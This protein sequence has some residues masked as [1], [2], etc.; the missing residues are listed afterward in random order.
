MTRLLIIGLMTVVLLGVFVGLNSCGETRPASLSELFENPPPEARPWA[1][2]YWMHGALSKDGLTRDLEAMKEAGFEGAYIFTIRGVPDEP[3][4][5][6][7]YHQL[8]PEWWEMVLHALSEAQRLELQIA[9]HVSDGFALAGGP[10]ISPEMSMQK[11]VWSEQTVRG[12]QKFD[13]LLEQPETVADYYKD[14]AVYAY[15]AVS[16]AA[17]STRTQRPV[18]TTSIPGVDALVLV[19]QDNELTISSN[20]PAWIQYAFEEPFLCRS[21]SVKSQWADYQSRRL[22]IQVSDDGENFREVL[23]L[24]PPRMGWQDYEYASTFAIGEVKSRFFRFVFDPIGSE[25]GAEDLDPAK[26]SPRLRIRGLELFSSP[27]INQYEGKSGAVWRISPREDNDLVPGH[28]YMD[29]AQVVVLSSKMD[30]AGRLEWEVPPGD[31]TILRMGH[32]STGH[33]NATGGA[34]IGLEADK[35]NPEAVRLQFDNWLGAAVE[36]AGPDLAKVISMF[37]V[38]S[39]E[40]GSQNWSPVFR[41]EF[42]HRRGYDPLSY[43]PIMAGVPLG[44]AEFSERFLYDVRS[45]ISDLVVENFFGTLE[46]LANE[47]GANFSAESLSPVF[48][49][50]DME[51]YRHVNHPMG[52][53]WLNSPSHDKPN[54][55]LDAIS[56]A[57]MYGH[58]IVQAE[59]FTQVRMEWDEHPGMLKAL[60]D[61]HFALGVNRFVFHVF[62]HNPWMEQKQPG[63]TL[64]G[65]GLFLQPDQTWWK[66]GF[67]WFD[68][69][70]RSQALLQEGVPVADVA[71]FTGEEVP[72]RALLPDRLVTVLPGLFGPDRVEREVERLSNTELKTRQRPVGVKTSANMAV[73]EDWSDPLKGY[74]Y[75]SFNKDALMNLATVKDGR[76]VL[77][78]GASYG[79]LVIPGSRRMN[80]DA[81]RM[82]LQV[83]R[84]ILELVKE[85]GTVVFEERP[86]QTLGLSAMGKDD[87]ELQ[88]IMAE[89]WD[90]EELVVADPEEGEITY[91]KVGKGRV[92]KGSYEAASLQPIGLSRDLIIRDA[93]GQR[94]E[95]VAWVHRQADHAEIYFLSN[96]TADR[97]AL[98]LSFR[99]SGLRPW[100]Y[101]AVSGTIEEVS[102]WEMKDGRTDL[103]LVLEPNGSVFVVFEGPTKQKKREGS[104]AMEAALEKRF[105]IQGPWRV[106]FDSNFGGPSEEVTLEHLMDWT[107]HE[108]ESVQTYSGTAKY[109]VDFDWQPEANGHRYWLSPGS[110]GSIAEVR[111]NGKDLGVLWTPPF[112]LEVTDVLQTGLNQL[113]IFITNTWRNR[114]LADRDKA[115]EER[116][117]DFFG[118]WYIEGKDPMPSGLLGPVTIVAR[119]EH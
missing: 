61:K 85:G 40:C 21:L 76:I 64:D 13:Q 67:A 46:T 72:R 81:N 26:W 71:V 18:V 5:E 102:S 3:L 70:T 66:P 7:S 80:P 23:R 101:D 51:H 56:G 98:Q 87:A 9:Y 109:C 44:S 29:T 53:F 35:L 55:I 110:F 88:A 84:K 49:S 105:A 83:A 73:W 63:M 104:P 97:N 11:L 43:L 82:S 99:V 117:A 50:D 31:W 33:T 37:H 39:W 45:T 28:L 79:V 119:P 2:W 25:P 59:A 118:R 74:A 91:Q 108:N 34:A 57:R 62:M 106:A 103:D 38:D 8:S 65:I 107:L 93:D 20:S 95:Q 17:H 86:T 111:L 24:D 10:W 30:E 22:I 19:N 115:P 16:N 96:Q 69:I 112:R 41:K 94:V 89:L 27:R 90:G 60:G 14:I 77:P 92:I 6:P 100:L 54:D 1:Y 78:G 58:T 114:L 47:N 4:I 75:D 32:T 116:R 68:Y 15:P 36:E 52:E 42:I 48:I 12:P 113:E